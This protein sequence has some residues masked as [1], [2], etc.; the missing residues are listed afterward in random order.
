MA[1]PTNQQVVRGAPEGDFDEFDE[2]FQEQKQQDPRFAGSVADATCRSALLVHLV[3]CRQVSGL[4]QAVVAKA[5]ETTQSAVSE[6]EGGITDPR[7]S[8]LQ[9]Y[10][11]ALNCALRVH[12][13][14]VYQHGY[15]P[16]S[17]SPL[18]GGGV[19]DVGSFNISNGVAPTYTQAWT[20]RE[21]GLSTSLHL[22]S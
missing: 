17:L 3:R 15:I 11:R 12:V 6:L 1:K 7:L 4:S 10:A 18:E 2:W 20:L 8:T 9:R 19:V 21:L 14:P 13:E 22:D 5:M 16:L